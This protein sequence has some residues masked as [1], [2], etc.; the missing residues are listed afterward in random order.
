MLR[1]P[2]FSQTLRAIYNLKVRQG[3]KFV[4]ID[5][6]NLYETTILKHLCH[7][8]IVVSVKDTSKQQKRLQEKD[9]DLSEDDA[10]K[11]IV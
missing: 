8:I 2:F 6:P 11:M 5:V 9:K 1:W 10:Q 3:E 4:V 7:P